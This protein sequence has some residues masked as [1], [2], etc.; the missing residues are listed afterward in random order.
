MSGQE[1]GARSRPTI[2]R[3]GK[4]YATLWKSVGSNPLAITGCDVQQGQGRPFCALI[5]LA[6]PEPKWE[7]QRSYDEGA[8]GKSK[9]TRPQLQCPNEGT[10]KA[11]GGGSALCRGA[12]DWRDLKASVVW[13]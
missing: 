1:L 7:S 13:R 2:G 11:E 10:K 6:D 9:R 5:D 3:P 8:V 4:V 12:A